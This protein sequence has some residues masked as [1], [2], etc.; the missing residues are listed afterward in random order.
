MYKNPTLCSTEDTEDIQPMRERYQDVNKNGIKFME[1][2]SVNTETNN[3]SAILL[4]LLLLGVI[5]L[6]QLQNTFY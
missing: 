1:N 2:V 6:K 4:L 5:L 3:K